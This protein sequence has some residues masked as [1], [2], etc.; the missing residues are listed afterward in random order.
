MYYLER[1]T[2]ISY[3]HRHNS[4]NNQKVSTI[5]AKSPLFPY[6][7]DVLCIATGLRL[8]P[9]CSALKGLQSCNNN[10]VYAIVVEQN[11]MDLKSSVN[12]IFKIYFVA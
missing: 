2:F 5:T 6:F 3:N 4:K 9:D 1:A 7:R 12:H 11:G 10:V 8:I